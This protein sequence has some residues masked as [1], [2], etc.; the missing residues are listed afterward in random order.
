VIPSKEYNISIN[1]YSN[2]YY[3]HYNTKQSS[4]GYKVMEL[5]HNLQIEMEVTIRI[6]QCDRHILAIMAEDYLGN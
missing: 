1:L 2:E 4:I 5:I 6:V 3:R